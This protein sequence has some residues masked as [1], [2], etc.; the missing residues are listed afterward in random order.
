MID[1]TSMS[2]NIKTN[3]ASDDETIAKLILEQ[4]KYM[5]EHKTDNLIPAVNDFKQ[6]ISK[7]PTLRI[8]MNKM[9]QEVPW[10]F[11]YNHPDKFTDIYIKNIDEM[12][13]LLNTVLT[14]KCV[15]SVDKCP[16]DAIFNWCRNTPTGDEFF[17]NE[18]INNHINNIMETCK[19]NN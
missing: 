15:Y 17:S 19:K 3:E 10:W 2:K 13:L 6:M 12:I 18:I 11:K 1:L 7:N 5:T 4:K 16:I 14:T 9:I 8:A